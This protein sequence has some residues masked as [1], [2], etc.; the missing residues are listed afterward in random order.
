MDY[1]PITC[2][3]GFSLSF[4]PSVH[5][6]ERGGK[7]STAVVVQ[8]LRCARIEKA[9]GTGC[10]SEYAP[11]GEEY[12][13]AIFNLKMPGRPNRPRT[14]LNPSSAATFM[15]IPPCRGSQP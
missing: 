1:L 6:P 10:L 12:D 2:T 3:L 14:P 8:W 9:A 13:A 11:R 15:V 7:G 4:M 5:S